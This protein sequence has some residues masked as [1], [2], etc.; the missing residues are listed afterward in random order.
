MHT[1]V[2]QILA[3]WPSIYPLNL[4]HSPNLTKNNIRPHKIHC[5]LVKSNKA[6]RCD[7]VHADIVVV[8]GGEQAMRCSFEWSAIL[9]FYL[10]MMKNIAADCRNYWTLCSLFLPEAQEH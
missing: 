2:Q 7:D 9:M 5:A 3:K 4:R 6:S 8:G 10:T 1:P